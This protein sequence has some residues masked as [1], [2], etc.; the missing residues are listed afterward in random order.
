MTDREFIDSI[1]V[2]ALQKDVCRL[3]AVQHPG[4]TVTVD[5]HFNT[6]GEG[7]AFAEYDVNGVFKGHAYI[8]RN[9]DVTLCELA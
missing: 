5:P 3:A 4:A 1:N 6:D 8:C 2:D 9:G 7:N